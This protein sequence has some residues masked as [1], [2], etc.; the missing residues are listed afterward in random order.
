MR[1]LFA[2][3][4]SVAFSNLVIIALSVFGGLLAVFAALCA[5]SVRVRSLD[6]KPVFHFVNAFTAVFFSLLLI[7][8]EVKQSLFYSAV[9][10][11]IGY[12]YYGAVCAFARPAARRAA[13]RGGTYLSAVSP[14]EPA[15]RVE[16]PAAQS[17]VRLGHALSIADKLLLKPLSRADRQE[18]EK[19]KT[20]LTVLQI[21]G[22]PSPQESQ[23]INNHFNALLK[24]MAKYDY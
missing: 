15:R 16:A 3:L 21:K 2:A 12:L 11:L 23:I 10:W 19:I 5:L 6:K 1:S 7:D 20:S 18:L 24:L 9:F 22:E 17:G 13:G 4:S 14:P 8:M